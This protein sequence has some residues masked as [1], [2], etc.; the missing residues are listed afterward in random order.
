MQVR[1]QAALHSDFRNFYTIKMQR[2]ITNISLQLHSQ[3][4][5]TAELLEINNNNNRGSE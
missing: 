1:Y 2:A 3:M 5:Y 4:N